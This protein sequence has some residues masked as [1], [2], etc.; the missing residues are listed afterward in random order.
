MLACRR[1]KRATARERAHLKLVVGRRHDVSRGLVPH[2]SIRNLVVEVEGLLGGRVDLN[3]DKRFG[4]Q[5]RRPC[6]CVSRGPAENRARCG[7]IA[8]YLLGAHP[9]FGGVQLGDQVLPHRLSC[10]DQY[11]KTPN[12]ETTGCT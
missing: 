6:A 9:F 4:V 1:Q 7:G 3:P 5:L 10:A 12:K 8:V 11:G 2:H